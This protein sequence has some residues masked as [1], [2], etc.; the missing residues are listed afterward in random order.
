M[1]TPKNKTRPHPNPPTYPDLAVQTLKQEGK[2]NL[3]TPHDTGKSRHVAYRIF[4]ATALGTLKSTVVV[5]LLRSKLAT[6][7]N[8]FTHVRNRVIWPHELFSALYNLHFTAFTEHILGGSDANIARFWETMPSRPGM[9][10]RRQSQ[11]KHRCVPLALH[12]DGVSITNIRGASSKTIDCLSWSSLLSTGP[13]RFTCYLIWFCF[14]HLSKKTGF[15]STWKV[16]WR[17]LGASLR[18]LWTGLWPAQTMEGHPEPRAG[19]PLAGGYCAIIYVNKGDLDWM[20]AHFGLPHSSSL[21]PCALCECSNRGRGLDVMPWTDVNNPPSWERSR[22][23]DEAHQKQK[24][25]TA[26]LEG[27]SLD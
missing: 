9:D 16:F 1:A 13:T 3:A 27:R 20:S 19:T 10:S 12:G 5:A 22:R 26:K 25:A 8:D 17:Q 11:W 4:K 6:T 24:S 18:A 2:P 7:M 15:G 21:Q 23:S 14:S